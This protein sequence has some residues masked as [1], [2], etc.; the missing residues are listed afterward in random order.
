MSI[1][2]ITGDLL[3]LFDQGEFDVIVHGCNCFCVMGGGIA[4]T[5]KQKYPGVFALDKKTKKG[6]RG[7]LGT[8]GVFKKGNQFIVNCYTEYD[9][10]EK[11]PIDY[12]SLENCMRYIKSNF[13]G[14]R[15][16]FPKIGAGLAGGDWK[17]IE[18]IISKELQ[19]EDVTVVIYG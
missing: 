18:G 4:K 8:C 7:K 14:K 15:I 9:Y 19:G 16:G 11:K 17:I 12:P 6:D 10:R 5:I 3:Q 2:Y 1:K 13:S